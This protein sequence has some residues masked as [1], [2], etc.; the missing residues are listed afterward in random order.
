M[1]KAI[2][3]LTLSGTL[4]HG[5]N[6]T[7]DQSKRVNV[8]ATDFVTIQTSGKID[9]TA[10]GYAGVD[11]SNGYGPGYGGKHGHEGGGGSGGGG[12]GEGGFG[13]SW[14]GLPG[15]AGTVYGSL[16]QPTHLGSGG[17]SCYRAGVPPYTR[18]GYGAGA[19]KLE[20]G[21][22]LTVNG[23]IIADGEAGGLGGDGPRWGSGGGG[24]GSV[25]IQ[26]STLDGTGLVRANGGNGGHIEWFSG[27]G[28]GGGRLAIYYGSGT[29]PTTQ[30]RGGGGTTGEHGGAGT[31]YLKQGGLA[32]SLI[33]ENETA[34]P[35]YGTR[36][37]WTTSAILQT[38][39]EI[40]IQSR[41]RL[42]QPT[43]DTDGV[44][45]TLTA[46]TIDGTSAID[47]LG[48]GYAGGY[49]KQDGV[50]PGK[51]G[52]NENGGAAGAGY[53]GVGGLGR[54]W[55]DP[56][57]RPAGGTYGS[58]IEPTQLGSGGGGCY[59]DGTSR[60]G[61]YGGGLVKLDVRN[62][63]LNGSIIAIGGD[64]EDHATDF[65]GGGGS[66]GSIWVTASVLTGTGHMQAAGGE[67][68]YREGYFDGGGGG[69][70]RI[71][72]YYTKLL[73]DTN[74]TSVLGGDSV[75]ATDGAPG[76]RYFQF[77]PGPGTLILFR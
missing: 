31:I 68:G 50:G 5:V 13:R 9:V 21:G 77:V 55:R 66:G 63:T 19:V 69:G 34:S 3:S 44:T 30:A 17:G 41:G 72:V 36:G 53:G 33:I 62:L 39:R 74:H 46:L 40:T 38:C 37:T 43:G 27:G 16:L 12:G 75:G 8:I 51:G 26:C 76:T 23:S 47:V 60:W 48:L 1:T 18:G 4:T 65:P 29:V 2:K 35:F 22:A 42:K 54:N 49:G 52:W 28:G 73:W 15:V 64:G 11:N 59:R 70:G 20:V 45:V 10:K 7:S 24:G 67:G 58:A 56:A 25:W 61:G 71:A 6:G 14:R 57:P 32:A